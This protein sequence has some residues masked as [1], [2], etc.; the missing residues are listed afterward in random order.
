[1]SRKPSAKS[2]RSRGKPVRSE[3]SKTAADQPPGARAVSTARAATEDE[4]TAI[5]R[6]Q[7]GQHSAESFW[8]AAG[9]LTKLR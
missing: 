4:L 7:Q 6:A 5:A 3:A 1:M 9:R 2:H 8:K